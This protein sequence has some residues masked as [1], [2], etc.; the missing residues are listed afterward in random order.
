MVRVQIQL[1]SAQH[2]DLTQGAKRLGVSV[3]E[4]VRRCVD[5]QHRSHER[6]ARTERVYRALAVV[7]KY[8]DPQGQTNVARD[9]DAVLAEAYR[10]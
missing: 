5:V 9:H 7:G 6:E 4:L 10:R 3:A 1:T 2:R 8:R